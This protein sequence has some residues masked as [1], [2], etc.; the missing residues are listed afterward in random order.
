LYIRA[1]LENIG[2][3]KNI[4]LDLSNESDIRRAISSWDNGVGKTTILRS[5]ALGLCDETSAL[6]YLAS[7]NYG[8]YSEGRRNGTVKIVMELISPDDQRSYD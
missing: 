5:I 4:A 6:P 2:P 1:H 7:S 8:T 3:F